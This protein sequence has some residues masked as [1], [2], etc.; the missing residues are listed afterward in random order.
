MIQSFNYAGSYAPSSTPPD[1]PPTL[2]SLYP[3]GGRDYGIQW[4]NGDALAETEIGFNATEDV[5]PTSYTQKVPPGTTSYDLRTRNKCYWW[6]RHKRG[7]QYSA[8]VEAVNEFGC[9]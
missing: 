5:E 1:G 3:Y 7:G 4:V 6:V 8:W 2:V 9:S